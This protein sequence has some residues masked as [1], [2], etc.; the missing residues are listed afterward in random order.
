[1][2]I[3]FRRPAISR[4]RP[5]STRP[6]KIV[7]FADV[8]DGAC[9]SR[10]VFRDKMVFLGTLDATGFADDYQVP[11]S[12]EGGKMAGV[13]LRRP[14]PLRRSSPRSSSASSSFRRLGRR[15]IG[16]AM[17]DDRPYGLPIQEIIDQ[18]RLARCSLAAPTS[19]AAFGNIRRRRLGSERGCSSEPRLPDVFHRG[20]APRRGD[21]SGRI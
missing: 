5:C 6:F 20:N 10:S 4:P 1:M 9:G 16:P 8:L 15:W 2:I 3:T 18:H 7:S 19:F 17:P 11:T 21:L 14:G 13:E 12:I